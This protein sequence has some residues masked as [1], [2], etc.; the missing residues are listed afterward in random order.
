VQRSKIDNSGLYAK[1]RLVILATQEMCAICGGYVDKTLK[2]PHPMSAEIDHIIPLNKGG[3]STLDNLQ[4]TH[5]QCNRLK[6]DKLSVKIPSKKRKF[7]QPII[8]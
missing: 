3:R 2:T 5:R 4:L 1:N 6:S 7:P 8:F